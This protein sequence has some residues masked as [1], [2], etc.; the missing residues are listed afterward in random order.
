[1]NI[2]MK[3]FIAFAL[4][5]VLVLCLIPVSVF[6]D[7]DSDDVETVRV[8]ITL[9]DDSEFITGN[10]AD[11]RVMARVPIDVPYVDLQE[12][13][14][15]AYNRY[16]AK[17]FEDGGTYITP[18]VLVE[19]PTLL[20][21]FLK[22]LSQYY[23]GREI[24]AADI[25]THAI[26][27]SGGATSLYLL[28]FFGHYYNFMYFVNHEYPLMA[29]GWGATADYI[30]LEDEDEI[31][32]GMFTD[33]RFNQYGG[34]AYFDSGNENITAGDS[35][36]LL[37]YLTKSQESGGSDYNGPMYKEPIRVSSDYGRT[38]QKKVYTTDKQ[39]SFTASFDEAGVYYISAGPVF[40]NQTYSS[41]QCIAPP[42]CIVE[43]RPAPITGGTASEAE[44]GFNVSWEPSPGAE[45]Y[46][47]T[48]QASTGSMR[49]IT[50]ESTSISVSD[51]D[52][53]DVSFS[54][55]PYVTDRYVAMGEDDKILRG[56]AVTISYD[57]ES[58]AARALAEARTS[59]KAQLDEYIS[60]KDMSLYRDAQ[61][62]EL[63]QAVSAGKDAIDAA[64]DI[65]GVTTALEAAKAAVDAVKTDAELTAE[66]LAAKKTAACEELDGYKD[67]DLY[68]Y[69]EKLQIISILSEEKENIMDAADADSVDMILA[70]AKERLDALKTDAEYK[71]EEEAEAASILEAAKVSACS[72]LEMYKDPALYRSAEQE[73]ISGIIAE[74]KEKIREAA[75]TDT[76]SS[77]LEA[78]KARL[79]AVKTDAELTE[80]E[81]EAA[82]Q[83][84]ARQLAEAKSNA[85]LDLGI[86]MAP[87]EYRDAEKALLLEI[88]AEGES[89][90]D[91]A[92]TR[93]EVALLLAEYKARID[94]LKTDAEYTQEEEKARKEQEEKERKAKEAAIKKAKAAKTTVKVKALTKHRAKVTWKKVTLSYTVDGKKYTRAVTGYK[95]YRA[96]KKN[97]KYKL[98]KTV[99]KAKTLKYT[100]KKLKKGKK[101][102][103][104]VRTYTMIDGTAYLGKWSKVKAIRAK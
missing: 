104:K 31:D 3:R 59:A 58:D 63:A 48:Y 4:S 22:A 62:A 87:S 36:D 98:V 25:G 9:S 88:L 12:Y 18:Y 95:I 30:L 90:I 44:D 6:A 70:A 21:C 51:V 43:V 77:L 20:M 38:W 24:T 82:R 65:P 94:E 60:G 35:L 2:L 49:T 79:D 50:T 47:V 17:S 81:E 10:D 69:Q 71:A 83:E 23:L 80:E 42:I 57:P 45:G 101:Y 26:E 61:K 53:S 74:E 67:P 102:F 32:I 76:V 89:A 99:K 75:D 68:R 55:I 73:Q 28:W 72:E 66:E 19:R 84:A 54:I 86:Y 46:E 56:E 37:L 39:G 78:A 41:L 14:L 13:G 93:E 15:E 5:T 1:M 29:K 8:Y 16:K 100:D 64:E 40:K 52:L 96:T 33:L 7:E 97:G 27:T 34:F 103:Y 85:K 11:G 92:E 91:A